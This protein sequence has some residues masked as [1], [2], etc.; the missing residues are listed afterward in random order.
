M[1]LD[2]KSAFIHIDIWEEFKFKLL[3]KFGNQEV[4]R[5]EALKQFSQLEQLLHSMHNLTT[6]LAPRINILKSY[7]QNFEEPE[8]LY[9][10]T[11]SSAL[12][13]TIIQCRIGVC[14]TFIP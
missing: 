1:F 9:A 13:D 8:A 11:L 5:C 6:L 14:I 10:T 3:N 12:N 4:F 7:M 2:K